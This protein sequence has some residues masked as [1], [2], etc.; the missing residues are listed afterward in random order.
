VRDHGPGIAEEDL[1][2]IFE[3]FYKQRSEANK[4]GTGLGLAIAKQ[5]A[6]RHGAGLKA[7]NRDEGCEFVLAFGVHS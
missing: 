3:Q 4:S 1:P 7:V 5:T 2:Y 6:R